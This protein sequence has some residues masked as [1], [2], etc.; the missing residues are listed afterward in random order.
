MNLQP[1]FPEPRIQATGTIVRHERGTLFVL[2]AIMSVLNTGML[3]VVLW[4][5]F[6]QLAY[7]VPGLRTTVVLPVFWGP[8]G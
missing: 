3:I 7:S 5:A 4:V 6:H 1:D 2:I 8:R